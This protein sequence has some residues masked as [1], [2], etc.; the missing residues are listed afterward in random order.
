MQHASMHLRQVRRSMDTHDKYVQMSGGVVGVC[1]CGGCGVGVEGVVWV[2]SEFG[3][4]GVGVKGV[5]GVWW[6]CGKCVVGVG[7]S[8]RGPVRGWLN[9]RT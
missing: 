9:V 8:M 6:V 2:W 3:G 7:C 1:G 4:C 5:V